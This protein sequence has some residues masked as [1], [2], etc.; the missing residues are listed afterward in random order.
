MKVQPYVSSEDGEIFDLKF[1]TN[2]IIFEII[3]LTKGE[4]EE[5]INDIKTQTSLLEEAYKK[6]D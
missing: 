6:V 2:E 5:L 4:V 3:E 1:C